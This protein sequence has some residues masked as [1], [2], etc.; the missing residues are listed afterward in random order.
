LKCTPPTGF[1]K[2]KDINKSLENHAKQAL[3]WGVDVLPKP[4]AKKA[5]AESPPL[6]K[7]PS[8]APLA[9]GEPGALQALR[10][11]IGDC[12]RCPLHQERTMIV[13]GEGNPN[14]DIMFV[15]EA[16]GA[17][18]DKSGIP[19]V[20]RAGKLLT[21]MILAMGL[22]REQIYIA[23]VV[24]CRPPGNRNP[25]PI[26]IASCIPFLKK[27]IESVKPK[28]II[29]LGKF[30]SQTLLQTE[31]PIT[32]LRG[33]FKEY[34]GAQLMP[35]YHPAYLLRNPPMKRAVW[36][37]LQKVMHLLNLPLPNK[38]TTATS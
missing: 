36:E 5:K 9:A 27:Q 30:A 3:A 33:E 31:I 20:G 34:E 37:D 14:A 1:I 35:T 13:F 2:M 18:E 12:T 21:D 26:E 11:H 22:T 19:F 32:K 24:K 7:P 23:N 16:P 28:A 17:D 38:K 10:S 6:P 29:A 8:E 15:G 25:E 4:K